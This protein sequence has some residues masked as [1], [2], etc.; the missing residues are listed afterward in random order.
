VG[1]GQRP[2]LVRRGPGSGRRPRRLLGDRRRRDPGARAHGALQLDIGIPQRNFVHI[3]LPEGVSAGTEHLFFIPGGEESGGWEIAPDGSVRCRRAL[4]GSLEM[5]SV[6]AE[7]DYGVALNIRLTN[8]GNAVLPAVS[9]GTCVQF[10]AAPDLRDFDLERTFWRCQD[11]WARFVV[12]ERVQGGRCLFFRHPEPAD[13]PLIVVASDTGP[14][15][16]GLI[17]RGAE[18]V[19]GNCQGSIGCIHSPAP[20]A[21]IPVGGTLELEGYLIIHPGG[22]AAVPPRPAGTRLCRRRLRRLRRSP[23]SEEQRTESFLGNSQKIKYQLN[24]QEAN[25]DPATL[26]SPYETRLQYDGQS[27]VDYFLGVTLAR[28]SDD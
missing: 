15:A 6:V 26:S 7:V 9:A 22:R 13:L 28:R 11:K 1:A 2:D 8:S 14:Y 5:E 25:T 17:F 18:G 4:T 12:T 21:D 20:A 24:N 10:A 16:A 23:R 27:V 3:W 19:G